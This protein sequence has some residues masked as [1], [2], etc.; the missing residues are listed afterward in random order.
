MIRRHHVMLA[1]A[2]LMATC[3]VIAPRAHAASWLDPPYLY[4]YFFWGIPTQ[5]DRSDQYKWFPSRPVQN[6]AHK[7]QFTPGPAESVPAVVEY[8][9]GNSVKRAALGDL[10]RS[11]DTHA[12]IVARD[13]KV[14][15][16][17]YFNGFQRNS[18]NESWSVAKSFVSALVG[19]ATGVGW[20]KSIDDPITDYLPELKAQ[21][22]FDAITIR[23][24]LTMGSGIRYRFGLFPWDEFV[25]AGFYPE[26]RQV[27]LTDM[28]IVEPP[29]KTFHYNNFNTELL[30]MILERATHRTLSLYL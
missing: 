29:G 2:A 19:I 9:E 15:Y 23:N 30:A 18:L 21:Q 14:L 27:L 8:Q 25:L 1:A 3:L 7:F 26:L 5:L 20:I 10:L 13:D 11:T 16:E 22:G 6:G 4:R 28:K 17:S 24:L 12:F